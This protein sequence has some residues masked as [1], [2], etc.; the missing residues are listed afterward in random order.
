MEAPESKLGFNRSYSKFNNF[1]L[2]QSLNISSLTDNSLQNLAN[3]IPEMKHMC[4][5]SI[6]NTLKI[7]RSLPSTGH[8][9][10]L[11]YSQP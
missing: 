5:F 7:N 4:V 6:N 8:P 11:N 9:Q 1:S 3:K 10:K 2:I